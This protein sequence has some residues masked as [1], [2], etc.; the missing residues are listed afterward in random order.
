MNFTTIHAKKTKQVAWL[1]ELLQLFR[2]VKAQ[3]EPQAPDQPQTAATGSG[4]A[5]GAEAATVAGAATEAATA[6]L[7][8]KGKLVVETWSYAEFLKFEVEATEIATLQ[9]PSSCCKKPALH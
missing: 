7:S 5:T 3:G 9:T 4:A 2:T 1:V 8:T 6:A